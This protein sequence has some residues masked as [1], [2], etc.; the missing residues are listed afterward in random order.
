MWF[1]LRVLPGRCGTPPS[2]PMCIIPATKHRGRNNM[3]IGWKP[4]R[5]FVFIPLALLLFML[6][7]VA[8]PNVALAARGDAVGAATQMPAFYEDQMVTVN[9]KEQ[10]AGASMALIAHN[11]S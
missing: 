1:E 4:A 11:G 5:A 7:A 9:M 3:A 6:G 2:G 10:P 8:Q